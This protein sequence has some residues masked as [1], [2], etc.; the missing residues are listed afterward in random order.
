MK[1]LFYVFALGLAL[2]GCL[3][4]P[5]NPNIRVVER[6]LIKQWYKV[7]H[8]IASRLLPVDNLHSYS[9]QEAVTYMDWATSYCAEQQL[10]P[11]SR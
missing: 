6:S 2:T 11:P 5:P 3:S 8:G 4:S 1:N 10:R 9:S 7:D